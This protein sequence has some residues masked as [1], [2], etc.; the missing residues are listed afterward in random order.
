MIRLAE[1]KDLFYFIE[2]VDNLRF[3]SHN[4]WSNDLQ[5]NNEYLT[6]MFKALVDQG[7]LIV[8]EKNNKPVGI[9]AG[10]INPFLWEPTKNIMY[11]I[12]F[13]V[14]EI[15]NKAKIGYK[16][17]DAYNTIGKE[18]MNKKIIYKYA[19][20]ASEPMFNLNLEKF[21]YKLIEKTWVVGE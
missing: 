2:G 17:I 13:Y 5:P 4:D 19:F 7:T 9:I 6:N 16:L 12:L 1:Y 10:L 15:P 21:N 18:L 3:R 8:Y 14:S 20:T 11:Q